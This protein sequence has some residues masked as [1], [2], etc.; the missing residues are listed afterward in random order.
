MTLLQN[1]ILEP[2]LVANR[3]VAGTA[4][5]LFFATDLLVLY[6]DNG[7]SWDSIEG[8][9]GSGGVSD[10][11]KGDITVSVGGTVWTLNDVY[12]LAGIA[13]GL[14]AT[15]SS[16]TTNIH[17]IVDTANII[18]E[19]DTR[20]TNARTPT[21]HSTSHKHSGG[22]EVATATPTADAIPKAGA[23][24]TLDKL[25]LPTMVASGAGHAQGV[26][27]DTPA[28]AGTAKFLREDATWQTPVVARARA[29]SG[30][31]NWYTIPGFS[32]HS[33]STTTL[34]VNGQRYEPVVVHTPIVLDQ[35]V[36]EV[37]TLGAGLA[38]LGIFNANENWQPTT[39]V[40]DGG[41]V[42]VSSTG[43]K[44]AS[45]NTTLQP[46][47]YLFSVNVNVSTGARI[48]LGNVPNQDIGPTA[49]LPVL[50]QWIVTTTF[51]AFADNPT[52]WTGLGGDN[53][54]FRHVVY[55]RIATP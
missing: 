7:S 50:P 40:V 55:C 33:I 44:T 5:R 18:I 10:G 11:D 54:P 32:Y 49:G 27:P 24:S 52:G 46:G 1:V 36:L 29:R 23:S 15:H 42:D 34:G 45:I 26:V 4:G 3:P 9:G 43:F 14:I 2:D 13:A 6:R 38:R 22:D 21:A 12:E 51:G 39:V 47:N 17:G 37:T 8:A 35:L 16:D 41:T 20:L 53:V 25:W 30:S 28:I 48:L 19:G 31:T